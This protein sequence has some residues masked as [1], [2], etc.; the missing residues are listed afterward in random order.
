[1]GALR[2]LLWKALNVME[3]KNQFK[4]VHMRR[5]CFLLL[6]PLL[7][8]LVWAVCVCFYDWSITND[9]AYF[10][11]SFKPHK[12][13]LCLL[14]S[15]LYHRLQEFY[16]R[17]RDNLTREIQEGPNPSFFEYF[18][19]KQITV[20]CLRRDGGLHRFRILQNKGGMNDT[21]I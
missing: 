16:I 18:F 17:T 4:N 19:F 15:I 8:Q 2:S 13:Y 7:V 20:F 14:Y 5:T 6:V 1:M 11:K 9:L 3:R 12:F 21:R 10:F